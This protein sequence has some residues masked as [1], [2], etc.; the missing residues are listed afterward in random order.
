MGAGWLA[1]CKVVIRK[2]M[3]SPQ[4]ELMNATIDTLV[5]YPYVLFEGGP[6]LFLHCSIFSWSQFSNLTPSF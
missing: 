1:E 4:I 6:H 3:L 5:F 2:T